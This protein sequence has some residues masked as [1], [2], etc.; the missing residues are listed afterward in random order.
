M[1]V[2]LNFLVVL[3]KKI[4]QPCEHP[5]TIASRHFLW[6]QVVTIEISFHFDTQLRMTEK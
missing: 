6:S 5:Y 4:L 3:G 1:I 2:L